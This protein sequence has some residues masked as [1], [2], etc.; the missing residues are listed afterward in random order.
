MGTEPSS[1]VTR[2]REDEQELI[3]LKRGMV[4]DA[5]RKLINVS[6]PVKSDPSTCLLDNRYNVLGF[7]ICQERLQL[8]S[9]VSRS[10][11]NE[12]KSF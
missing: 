12:L 4:H 6:Y 5:E 1:I 2:S 9:G 7:Q 11:N 8:K 10:Y 3:A